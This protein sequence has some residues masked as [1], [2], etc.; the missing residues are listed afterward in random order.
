MFETASINKQSDHSDYD[1]IIYLIR[2]EFSFLTGTNKNYRKLGESTRSN[3]N[4]YIR[5]PVTI[6]AGRADCR[7]YDHFK[8]CWYTRAIILSPGARES[9]I[10]GKEGFK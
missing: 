10:E 4:H 8:T 5:N 6:R 2:T 3:R 7:L 9:R 1:G